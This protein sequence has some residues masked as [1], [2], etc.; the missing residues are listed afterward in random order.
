M[1]HLKLATVSRNY[2]NMP[3]W[4][5]HHQGYFADENLDVQIELYEPIDEVTER[6]KDGRAQIGCGVTEHVILDSE[7]GGSLEIIAGNV[8]R[9]PFDLIASP[10]IRSFE[11]MRGKTVGVS[12]LEAG[13]SSLVMRLFS[14]HG[15]EFPGD[16]DIRAVG[17]ILTRWKMLESGEIQA[18]LQGIPLNYVALDAGYSS[19]AN[20]RDQ[21][22]NFQFTSINV[23]SSWASANSEIVVRFLRAC[24]RAHEW[25]YAHRDAATDIAVEKTG[26]ERPYALRAWDEYTRD[27]IFPRD[28][29]AGDDAVQ[30][31]IDVSSL[32]RA[33]PT[34][35]KTNAADY[36]NRAYLSEARS[37]LAMAL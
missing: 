11:D 2:F 13:S 22:P 32:I 9:L 33:L 37:R 30:T 36:I 24:I 4:V 34:R 3:L 20:P 17:P 14:A 16:Y 23:D 25:F 10:G 12:S 7:S 27:E 15:L 29:D 21:F 26:I 6:L 19:L 35:A 1:D 31:L 5:A 28:A 18:G 8:N